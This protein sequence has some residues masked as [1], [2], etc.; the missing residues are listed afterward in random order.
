MD[1]KTPVKDELIQ[2]GKLLSQEDVLQMW[3]IT[4]EYLSRLTN[5]RNEN[6][7]LPSYQL[8]RRRMYS[9]EDLMWYREKNRY[10]PKP[11]RGK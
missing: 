11:H 1:V 6:K 3:P 7:R 8:G 10:T 4:R 2:K 5:H 9:L